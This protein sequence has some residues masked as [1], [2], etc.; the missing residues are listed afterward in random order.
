MSIDNLLAI[1][2]LVFLGIDHIVKKSLRYL[3][4]PV[5]FTNVFV[6][7]NCVESLAYFPMPSFAT[8]LHT[9]NNHASG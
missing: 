8:V 2:S 5:I 3:N 1:S 9:Q 7:Q 4:E 6:G